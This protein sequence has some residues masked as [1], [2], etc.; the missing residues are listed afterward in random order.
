ME[1]LIHGSQHVDDY[2]EAHEIEIFSPL[3]AKNE[4]MSCQGISAFIITYYVYY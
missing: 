1:T 4:N 2:S 3:L